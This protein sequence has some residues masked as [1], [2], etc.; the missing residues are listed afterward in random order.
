[1]S[2]VIKCKM[3]T[4]YSIQRHRSKAESLMSNSIGQ[5]PMNW[6]TRLNLRPVRAIATR[7]GLTP[8]QGYGRVMTFL[9]R[10]LPYAIAQRALPLMCNDWV[11]TFT[12]KVLL[13]TC[14][15]GVQ[16]SINIKFSSV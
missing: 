10:A 1:M 13:L 15:N 8:F 16:Y 2:N 4:D 12:H 9:R 11:M 6:M 14:N 7:F 3:N 5:R